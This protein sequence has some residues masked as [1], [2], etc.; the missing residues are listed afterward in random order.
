MLYTI[1]SKNSKFF[2]K[3]N[4]LP[5]PGGRQDTVA[6]RFPPRVTVIHPAPNRRG[7]HATQ[8]G[9]VL[10]SLFLFTSWSAPPRTVC[11]NTRRPGRSPRFA[12]GTF[13]T[14]TTPVIHT[15]SAILLWFWRGIW[16]WA[17]A[18]RT[19]GQMG[20]ADPLENGWKIKKRKHAKK[21]SFLCLC[22]ILRAIRTGRCR[23]RCCANHI[24]SDI[25]QNAPFRSQ[26]FKIV[27]AS[28]GKG[29]MTPKP[30]SCGR[31]WIWVDPQAQFFRVT[32]WREQNYG[33]AE[34]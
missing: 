15:P 29:A 25:L 12:A 33:K 3:E 31:S 1:C 17:S 9:S 22:Y 26:I 8:S 34:K 11:G 4:G 2:L 6:D 19:H 7:V 23:E 30:K 28:G 10:S 18:V 21:S 20:S 5:N 24:Y 14:R 13:P 16:A 27:F 32:R